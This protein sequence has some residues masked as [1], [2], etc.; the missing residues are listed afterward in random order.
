M[1]ALLK[2]SVFLSLFLFNQLDAKAQPKGIHLS[3]NGRKEVNTS[4][5][6]AIS[7][8]DDLPNK[9]EIVYGK[10]S[11]NLNKKTRAN[12]EYVPAL[13]THLNKV[14][15]KKLTPATYY[16]Y[17]VGSEEN[18]W[19]RVYK[20]RTG[21]KKGDTAKIV[22]GIWSD[23]QNNGGNYN[24]EQTDTIVKQLSKNAF[25][26]TIHNGDMVENGSVVKNWKDLFNITQPINANSPFMSVTGN[27]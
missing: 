20:F 26:F 25:Y 17:K 9:G 6:M 10:D 15:L 2:I 21:S 3:W 1:K 4:Q 7:W 14:T 27:H 16:Y 22:V 24:F 11:L 19:S 5:T 12:V 23:T 13:M 8:M 18:G